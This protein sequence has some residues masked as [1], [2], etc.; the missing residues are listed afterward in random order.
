ML[1]I[2]DWK[3][4]LFAPP[5]YKYIRF[6]KGFVKRIEGGLV[7]T[8]CVQFIVKQ[9]VLNLNEQKRASPPRGVKVIATSKLRVLSGSIDSLTKLFVRFS[10]MKLL[11]TKLASIWQNRQRT[12]NWMIS[13]VI[14]TYAISRK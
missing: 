8:R 10:K 1:D 12:C 4:S 11:L 9:R 5:V 14:R 2:T 3:L 13:K 7:E 6:D